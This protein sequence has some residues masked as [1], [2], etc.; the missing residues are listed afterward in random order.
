MRRPPLTIRIVVY[1]VLT[2][3][4]AFFTV[5]VI[6]VLAQRHNFLEI[7]A[8]LFIIACLLLLGL[9]NATHHSKHP[10]S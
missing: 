1:L 8:A 10:E 6:P 4:I 7:S 9:I 5:W 3:L 2:S